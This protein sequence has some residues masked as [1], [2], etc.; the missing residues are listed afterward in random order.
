MW[1]KLHPKDQVTEYGIDMT[2][3]GQEVTTAS[4]TETNNADA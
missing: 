2:A 1:L 3:A 4:A